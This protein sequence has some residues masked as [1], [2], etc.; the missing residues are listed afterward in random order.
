MVKRYLKGI[1]RE[2]YRL[3]NG[4][5]F[6]KYDTNQNVQLHLKLDISDLP[7]ITRDS[8]NILGG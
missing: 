1:Y 2:I 5:I 3:P 4:N 8:K 6:F 7:I